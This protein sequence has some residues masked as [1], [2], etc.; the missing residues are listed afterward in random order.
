MCCDR[1]TQKSTLSPLL[2]LEVESMRTTARPSASSLH[3][4]FAK[5]HVHT[6]CACM[7]ARLPNSL[8]ET[9]Y[10]RVVD[11]CSSLIVARLEVTK[12]VVSSRRRTGTKGVGCYYTAVRC[13]M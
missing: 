13:S 3:Q 7:Y 1:T 6:P 8:F 9:Q 4:Q 11:S 10:Y 5:D 12:A 2:V